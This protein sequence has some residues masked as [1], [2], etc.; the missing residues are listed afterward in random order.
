VRIDFT[1]R[2]QSEDL[3]FGAVIVLIG[4][5]DRALHTLYARADLSSGTFPGGT[6]QH[7]VV[8]SV[9]RPPEWWQSI[10]KLAFFKMTYYPIQELDDAAIWAAMH[11]AV[12]HLTNGRGSE[13]VQK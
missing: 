2:Q 10:T 8:F 12:N 11:R 4:S 5:D 6:P 13:Q 7:P 1:A 9:F 3:R